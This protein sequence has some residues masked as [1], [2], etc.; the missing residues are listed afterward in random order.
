LNFPVSK[1]LASLFAS[2]TAMPVFLDTEKLGAYTV[3]LSEFKINPNRGSERVIIN[4]QGRNRPRILYHCGQSQQRR[5][6]CV[7][8]WRLQQVTGNQEQDSN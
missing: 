4:P 6:Y 8:D 1:V 7:A 3:Q 5:R 2:Q